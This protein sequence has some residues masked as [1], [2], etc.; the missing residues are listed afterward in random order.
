MDPTQM[1]CTP[2]ESETYKNTLLAVSNDLIWTGIRGE[3]LLQTANEARKG[4]G[5]V[6]DLTSLP[7]AAMMGVGA[8]RCL[9]PHVDHQTAL[10]YM[11][12]SHITGLC[13]DGLSPLKT[14]LTGSDVLMTIVL[15][16]GLGYLAA[17]KWDGNFSFWDALAIEAPVLA[18]QVALPRLSA[19]FA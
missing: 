7:A 2:E 11:T 12:I 14:Q 17:K 6:Y 3:R 16:T 10:V 9:R 19:L 8:A 5:I 4:L 1:S 15:K 13:M 18:V